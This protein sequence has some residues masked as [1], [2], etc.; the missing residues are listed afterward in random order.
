MIKIFMNLPNIFACAVCYGNPDSP[1]SRG[2]MMAVLT[3]IG[4]VSVVLTCFLVFGYS[5]WKK[6]DLVNE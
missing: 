3:L 6:R 5:L 2:L 4:V 1:I